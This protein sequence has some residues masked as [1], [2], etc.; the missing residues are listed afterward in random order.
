MDGHSY[1]A[2]YYNNFEYIT[3]FNISVAVQYSTAA[4]QVV[5]AL[6]FLLFIRFYY[7]CIYNCVNHLRKIIVANYNE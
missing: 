5:V 2:K 3:A 4:Q 1:R 6:L 7:K